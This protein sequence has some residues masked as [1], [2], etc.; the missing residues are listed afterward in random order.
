MTPQYPS[1]PGAQQCPPGH[2][3]ESHSD[4][5]PQGMPATARQ[6]PPSCST[7]PAVHALQLPQLSHAPQ[8]GVTAAAQQRPPTQLPEAHAPGVAHAAPAASVRHVPPTSARSVAHRVQT[9]IALGAGHATQ[10]ASLQAAMHVPGATRRRPAA[11]LLHAS[12]L[13][14]QAAQPAGHAVHAGLA[15]FCGT[16]LQLAV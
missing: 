10:Y 7:Y 4:A 16:R 3:P 11:Q 12:V 15:G 1:V 2:A 5:P 8:L 14:L 9:S 6:P 13:L